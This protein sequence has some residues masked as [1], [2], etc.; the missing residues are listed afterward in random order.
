MLDCCVHCC[1]LYASNCF[2]AVCTAAATSV[3]K[4]CVYYYLCWAHWLLFSW[5]ALFLSVQVELVYRAIY[6]G[7]AHSRVSQAY[8]CLADATLS[9]AW[10]R[11]QWRRASCCTVQQYVACFFHPLQRS[12]RAEMDRNVFC[13]QQSLVFLL[14]VF[15]LTLLSVCAAD[16]CAELTAVI[17]S[18]VYGQIQWRGRSPALC[19]GASASLYH[20]FLRLPRGRCLY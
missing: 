10:K 14:C 7:S 16:S 9:C 3:L 2:T 19:S 17:L 5:V 6:V 12:P 8:R 20:F 18:R 11:I 13:L 4:C 1:K 15:D